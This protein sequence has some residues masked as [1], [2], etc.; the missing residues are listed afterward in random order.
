MSNRILLTSLVVA[1]AAA[2]AAPA[3]NADPSSQPSSVRKCYFGGGIGEGDVRLT[4]ALNTVDNLAS[5]TSR[6]GSCSGSP[7]R[8]YT[9]VTASNFT[10]ADAK[11]EQLGRIYTN[12]QLAGNYNYAVPRNWWVCYGTN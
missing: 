8:L 9:V 4:G 2:L 6:D 12:G 11:C 10:Q 5:Y 7:V 1:V 3:V